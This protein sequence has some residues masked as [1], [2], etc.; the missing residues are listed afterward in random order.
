MY[1]GKLASRRK[2]C[3]CLIRGSH[4]IADVDRSRES[5]AMLRRIETGDAPKPFSQ[6]AQAIVIEPGSRLVYV[7]GQVGADRSGNIA[8]APEEQHRLAWEN[9]LA[10]LKAE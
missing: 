2:A 8:D 1:S 3:G 9:V 4:P 6:Y 7:A 10:I 5:L